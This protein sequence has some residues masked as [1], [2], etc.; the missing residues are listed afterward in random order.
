MKGYQR[1]VLYLILVIIFSFWTV[2]PLFH[3]GFFPMH[4]DT[5]P[6]RVYEMAQAL[7]HGQ[8]PVRWVGDLGYGYGYPLFNFYAPLPYYTGAIFNLIGFDSIVST[9]IMFFIGIILAGITMFYLLTNLVG[10]AGA[11]VGSLL[12][13]YAP[14]HAID[15][16]VRGA[17]SEIYAIGFLPLFLAG[18]YRIFSSKLVTHHKNNLFNLIPT[19]KSDKE[20]KKGIL[21]SII[22]F[23]VILL[24]HN[25]MGMIVIEFFIVGMIVYF[26][27]HLF[28]R[29][30]PTKLYLLMT[31]FL[32][33]LGISSFFILP[34]FAEKNFTR[35]NELITGGSKFSDHFV[36]LDQL[37]SS[38]WGFGG[39]ALGRADGMSFMI[40]KIHLLLG[41]LSIPVV[42][43]FHKRK[44]INNFQFSIFSSQLIL[45]VISVFLVLDISGYIWAL[46]PGF[47][48][49]QYPWR[50]LAISI[51]SISA[52]ISFIVVCLRKEIQL[53]F[54]IVFILLMIWFNSRYFVP[55]EY[56]PLKQSDYTSNLNLRY[57]ISKI[58]D[59]YLP[60]DFIIPKST[61]EIA[62][63]GINSSPDFKVKYFSDTPVKKLFN[64]ES[65]ASKSLQTNVAYF[66]GWQVKIDG[67]D[68]TLK[69]RNGRIEIFIPQGQHSI[70][71]NLRNTF[72]R[73]L[74]N[75]I[76]IFALFLL[77]YII[78]L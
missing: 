69:S 22:G 40:G 34:A 8:F 30:N 56:L 31:V 72:I 38:P 73:I 44:K 77:V 53:I 63:Q 39:S 5:Q 41:I 19:L 47:A 76:S 4:D 32:I 51:F 52:M 2:K 58:S 24:S 65:A 33:G 29:Q 26:L 49:I 11:L 28:K 23:A 21:T 78:V 66:P 25:L 14:Y 71:F 61:Y 27:F 13:M 20:I 46:M 75:S 17:V 59:E 67:F 43:I 1:R 74:S 48:Y 64:I 9:K 45:F 15:I 70:E 35:I 10:E 50:F 7:S 62:L 57:K 16:Y 37:W 18:I 36:Y 12:Y 54:C 3:E 42:L 55:K 60:Y 68:T 6:A